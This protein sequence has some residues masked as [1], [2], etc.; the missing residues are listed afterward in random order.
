MPATCENPST[1]SFSCRACAWQQAKRNDPTRRLDHGCCG[2]SVNKKERRLSIGASSVADTRDEGS[3][4]G[5][6]GRSVEH[7]TGERLW[8]LLRQIVPDPAGNQPVFILARKFFRV[9]GRLWMRCAIGITLQ[10]DSRHTDDRC[11]GE[12]LFEIVILRLARG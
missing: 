1:A 3:G 8:C 12:A 4:F 11:G 6:Q 10:G 5:S 2:S 7:R 9:S